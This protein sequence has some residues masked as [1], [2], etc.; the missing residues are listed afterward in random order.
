MPDAKI[1]RAEA[2]RI[3]YNMSGQ[4]FDL[5]L[6]AEFNDVAPSHWASN[7]LAWAIGQG[8]LKGSGNGAL[9]PNQNI[10]RAE[11][12]AVLHRVGQKEN[13]PNKVSL[14][15][16]TFND[17]NGHWAYNDII[18]LAK[19]GIV[20]GYN[21]GSFRPEKFVT[22]AEAVVMIARL[23]GRTQDFGLNTAF[24]DVPQ[25]HWAFA[26]IMNAANGYSLLL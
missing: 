24:S 19:N 8:Y 16:T 3:L 18:A 4:S 5:A 23:F 17:I 22:R 1:T 14:A 2:I 26:Y 6:L 9:R 7:A 25:S 10:T 20:N 21:D 11:L 15:S 12:A 13:L